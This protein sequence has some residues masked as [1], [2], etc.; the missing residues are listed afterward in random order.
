[1][2]LK[3]IPTGVGLPIAE[4]VK[5]INDAIE[6]AEQAKI[7]SSNAVS[8]SNSANQ[9]AQT[10]ETKADSVQEQFNQV[11]I[12][13]DSSVEAAQARVEKDGTSHQT[14]K[15]R[16]D[17]ENSEVT[18]RLA[19]IA[20]IT[21]SQVNILGDGSDETSK[22][23]SM[24]D[25]LPLHGGKLIFDKSK[26]IT[27]DSNSQ[28]VINGKKNIVIE[29]ANLTGSSGSVFNIKGGSSYITFRDCYFKNIGQVILLLD[30]ENITVDNCIFES[31][32][33]GIIQQIGYVS[34]NVKIINNIAN[35]VGTDFVE[36]NCETG[37]ISKNWTISGNHYL[38]NKD[39]PTEG[40]EDRFIGMTAVENVNIS[41]NICM[42]SAGDGAIHLEDPQ[43]NIIITGNHFENCVGS[44]AYLYFLDCGAVKNITI[45]NN[46]FIHSDE[47]LPTEW[48]M[49]L[50]SGNYKNPIIF[51]N[52]QIIGNTSYTLLGINFSSQTNM[53]V[54]GN[55]FEMVDSVLSAFS[56]GELIFSNNKIKNCNY[57]LLGDRSNDDT[58]SSLSNS[59]I[60]ANYFDCN[61]Q[62]VLLKGNSV[63]TG[64]PTNLSF[65]GNYFSSDAITDGIDV[66]AIGNRIS[67]GS[68]LRLGNTRLLQSNN[69][70]IGVGLIT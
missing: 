30:C 42:N 63:G 34:N 64:R 66:I 1:M 47:A 20:T 54:E 56:C 69:L 38:G 68:T 5:F 8:T 61:M 67:Q 11:V 40:T 26:E 59:N 13:G 29:G 21:S 48:V 9:T 25:S 27:V 23:K 39:F 51:S 28:L 3:T 12:D 14:L 7:E 19:D 24:I 70:E 52:N 16:L 62:S 6:A 50:S 41:N 31:T 49:N 46:I 58:G 45:T 60:E 57:G 43:G 15:E 33:Y 22:I 44:H 10:A 18:S 36:A 37:A 17:A 4:G 2:V 32:G 65:I 53:I 55:Y 35:N